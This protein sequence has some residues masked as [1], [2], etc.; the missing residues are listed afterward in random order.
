MVE[1]TNISLHRGTNR[2]LDE[3]SLTA[4]PGALTV[5]MGEN[6][7]GKSTLLKVAS[8]ELPPTSGTVLLNGRHLARLPAL[9]L[10]QQRAVLAQE[11]HVS[12]MFSAREV[13]LMGRSPHCRGYPG[14]RDQAIAD[15]ALARMDVHHLAHRLFPTLSGGERAR[16]SLARVLAQLWDPPA[17]GNRVL[18]LDEPVAALDIAHQHLALKVARDFAHANGAVV[19]AVL[20]DLNLT[21]Q[22][23]DKVALLKNGRLYAAGS[24]DECLIEPVLTACFSTPIQRIAHPESGRP[25]LIA[26]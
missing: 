14:K 26:A 8:G 23:A 11:N 16:V 25:L 17:S 5:L 9:V 22:Y 18:L 4:L 7:A 1:L 2:L 24:V 13:V 10:A 3:V 20:H 15:D 21:A 12:F 19:I 6:G